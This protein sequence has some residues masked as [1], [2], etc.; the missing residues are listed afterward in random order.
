MVAPSTERVLGHVQGYILMD[1]SS[2]WP[3]RLLH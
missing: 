2:R 3:S 1:I